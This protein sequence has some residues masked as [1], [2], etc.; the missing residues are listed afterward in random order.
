LLEALQTRPLA[1]HLAVKQALADEAEGVQLLLVIDQFEE[2]FAL[3][4]DEGERRRFIDALLFAVETEGGRTVVVPTIRADFY[5]RCADYPGLA[6]RLADSVLVGPLNEA[7]L[8]QAMEWPAAFVGLRLE[9]GL[10]DTIVD[11]V[12]G[13]PGALPLLSHALLETWE[14]RRG[15][16]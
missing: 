3:C 11:D 14:R 6:A 8:R 15:A 7:G 13:E 10:A 5:G 9:P 16:R 12:A 2:I 4:R 1:L